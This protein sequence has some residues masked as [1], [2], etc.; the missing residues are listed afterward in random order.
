VSVNGLDAAMILLPLNAFTCTHDDLRV[1]QL[2]VAGARR[3]ICV[4]MQTGIVY[5]NYVLCSTV[6]FRVTDIESSETKF[7]E[8]N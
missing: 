4:V 6:R 2:R 1:I 7:G 8:F 3:K 5:L